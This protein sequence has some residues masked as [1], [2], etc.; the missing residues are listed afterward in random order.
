MDK[1]STYHLSIM[2]TALISLFS[3]ALLSC[4]SGGKYSDVTVDEFK[5]G[6]AEDVTI[7]DVRTP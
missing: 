2:K 1:S 6:I 5:A 4:T 3:I 7:L